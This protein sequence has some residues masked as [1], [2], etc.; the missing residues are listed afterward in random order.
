MQE[1]QFIRLLIGGL[2]LTFLL[3]ADRAPGLDRIHIEI[4]NE[5][6]INTRNFVYSWSLYINLIYYGYFIAAIARKIE[7][8]RNWMIA[9]IGFMIF[10]S[11]FFLLGIFSDPHVFNILAL[12]AYSVVLVSLV[13]SFVGLHRIHQEEITDIEKLK[14][15]KTKALRKFTKINPDKHPKLYEELMERH[16]KVFIYLDLLNYTDKEEEK[17][18]YERLALY[19]YTAH[20]DELDKLIKRLSMYSTISTGEES[21]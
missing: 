10:W 14:K 18:E 19:E 9:S 3:F 16:K 8:R 1:K 2:I 12:M 20:K 4:I 15:W 5:H 17:S 21:K 11:I 13:L 6:Y 7:L